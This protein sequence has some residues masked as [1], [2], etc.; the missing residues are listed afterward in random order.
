M[1]I[2]FLII[3]FR[4]LKPENILFETKNEDST[5]KII[6]FGTSKIFNKKTSMHQQFGTV[7]KFTSYYL[8]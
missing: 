4:D 8:I 1:K 3:I 5:L 6:D 2:I 7:T